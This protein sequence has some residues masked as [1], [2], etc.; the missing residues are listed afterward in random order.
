MC[1]TCHAFAPPQHCMPV[2]PPLQIQSV[3][4]FPIRRGEHLDASQSSILGSAL[5]HLHWLL[6]PPGRPVHEAA[7]H[8]SHHVAPKLLGVPKAA[9]VGVVCRRRSHSCL[10]Q[11]MWGGQ[12][13]FAQG[14]C[15][16]SLV[17]PVEQDWV[18]AGCA[19]SWLRALCEEGD[20]SLRGRAGFA[21]ACRSW[22][23]KTQL[24]GQ[25]LTWPAQEL[26]ATMPSK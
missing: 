18:H 16:V 7:I 13:A 26:D 8:L 1:P 14:A 10:S 9:Q 2:P 15:T 23:G 19:C 20:R 17:H 6:G 4:G 25:W 3:N 22:R 11:C 5:P 21:I 24:K 12:C